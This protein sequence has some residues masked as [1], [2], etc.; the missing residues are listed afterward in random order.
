MSYQPTNLPAPVRRVY[1]LYDVQYITSHGDIEHTEYKFPAR[2]VFE[3]A[4]SAMARRTLIDTPKGPVAVE[5]LAP[6]N[7]V[8]SGSGPDKIAWIG[9]TMM[10]AHLPL[11]CA[12][13]LTNLVRIQASA[14]R[15]NADSDVVLGPLARVARRRPFSK[16]LED[17][18]IGPPA[19]LFGDAAFTIIP[20]SP[21]QMFH[22]M[23]E[24]AVGVM[25]QGLRIETLTAKH[26]MENAEEGDWTMI[27][28][29]LPHL[30]I[31]KPVGNYR[32]LT[33]L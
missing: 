20:T 11:A 21:M 25:S 5:D 26:I 28:Q 12:S 9:S 8:S 7:V 30:H 19:E 18:E 10:T 1:R 33:I 32:K 4:C 22:I 6:G 3:Q 2:S 29:L 16:D 27:A 23:L 13:T 24:S 17:F 31:Q 15:P 14:I